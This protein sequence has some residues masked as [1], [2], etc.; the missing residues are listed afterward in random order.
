MSKSLAAC[1]TDRPAVRTA[2]TKAVRSS[3][4]VLVPQGMTDPLRERIDHARKRH[5]CPCTICYPCPCAIHQ[6]APFGGLWFSQGF[7]R[8]FAQGRQDRQLSHSAAVPDARGGSCGSLRR[9]RPV[10]E[11]PTPFAA[12]GIPTLRTAPDRSGRFR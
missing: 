11:C 7:L 8:V 6:L 3:D 5:P 12:T 9:P 1:V 4:T 2:W 10:R